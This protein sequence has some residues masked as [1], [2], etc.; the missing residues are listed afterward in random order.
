MVHV[1]MVGFVTH[2]ACTGSNG[3]LLKAGGIVILPTAGWK[4]GWNTAKRF[5]L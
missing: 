2:E 4:N 3:V 5:I 1:T